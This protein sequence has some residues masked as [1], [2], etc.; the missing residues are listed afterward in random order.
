M[1]YKKGFAPIVVVIAVILAVAIGGIAY[2]AGKNSTSPKNIEVN[3]YQPQA[4]QSNP[5]DNSAQQ[6]ASMMDVSVYFSNTISDPGSPDCRINYPVSRSIPQ[7][8]A[9]ARAAL[10]ELFKGP[11]TAEYNAGFRTFLG[12]GITI[13]SLSIT[14][15]VAYLDLATLTGPGGSC[16]VA[17]MV[18][19][20]TKTLT[21]FPTVTSVVMTVKGQPS[22]TVLEA[23]I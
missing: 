8:Q 11:T 10:E 16:G 3:N 22:S 20:I 9:V 17:G 21:Q 18:S 19:Q 4:D 7:T 15:G 14:N 12:S 1:K 6:P 2:Y 5:Q 23:M 13:N